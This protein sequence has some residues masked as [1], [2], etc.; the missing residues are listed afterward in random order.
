LRE[1]PEDLGKALGTIPDDEEHRNY[2]LPPDHP[3]SRLRRERWELDKAAKGKV[4]AVL[5]PEQRDTVPDAR[6]G[7]A[8]FYDYTPW[9]L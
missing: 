7:T 2:E 6:P 4:D 8:T 5:T 3:V 1:V 9:G